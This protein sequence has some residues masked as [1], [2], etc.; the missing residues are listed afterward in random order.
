MPQH[1]NTAGLLSALAPR[2]DALRRSAAIEEPNFFQQAFGGPD[3]PRMNPAQMAQARQASVMRAG[4]AG[5]LAAGQGD[6]PLETLGKAGIAGLDAR[7]AINEAFEPPAA[8]EFLTQVVEIL[9]DDGFMHR[10]LVN[11]RTGQQIADL[12]V[13]ELPEKDEPENRSDP[14]MYVMPSGD[15]VLGSFN[16]DTGLLEDINTGQI[17]INAVAK[18]APVYGIP[19]IVEDPI[20]GKKFQ[21][22]RDPTSGEQIGTAMFV[23]MIDDDD[24]DSANDVTTAVLDARLQ[25]MRQLYAARGFRAFSIPDILLEKGGPFN[26]TRFLASTEIKNAIPAQTF[27]A[28]AVLKAVQGSRPSDFDMKMYLQF[29]LPQPGDEP[30]NIV[31]KLERMEEMVE[32]FKGNPV[33]WDKPGSAFEKTLNKARTEQGLG[34]WKSDEAEFDW[35]D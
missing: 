27:V 20:S 9:G 25:E 28:T 16:R 35:E 24:Q 4:F 3:D 15:E 19:T 29:L 26:I 1:P 31:R 18:V 23:G 2:N 8:K 21:I 22:F 34:V 5:L 30:E 17:M 14:K 7:L 10:I 6:N 13:S 11:K 32:A 33:R 12:G